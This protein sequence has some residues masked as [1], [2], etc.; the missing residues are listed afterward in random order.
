MKST[1]IVDQISII[2]LGVFAVLAFAEMCYLFYRGVTIHEEKATRYI[3]KNRKRVVWSPKSFGT[4]A[5]SLKPISI[6][7]GY[8]DEITIQK[9]DDNRLSVICWGKRRSPFWWFRLDKKIEIDIA[10]REAHG[11]NVADDLVIMNLFDN[12]QKEEI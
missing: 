4:G 6:G 9:L 5:Y 10:K 3:V 11:Y 1:S 2:M 7:V 12:Q 8:Y